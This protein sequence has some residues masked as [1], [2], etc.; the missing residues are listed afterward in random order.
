MAD[1]TSAN[2]FGEIFCMLAEN[3]SD[4]HKEMARRIFEHSREYDF[5]S[6]QMEA[7]SACLKLG[8]IRRGV[9]P[10]YPDEGIMNLWPNDDGY[11][12]VIG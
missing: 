5:S 1:R 8:L 4:E 3:P 10:H 9:N 7:D 11:E 2:I 6:Y 12:D